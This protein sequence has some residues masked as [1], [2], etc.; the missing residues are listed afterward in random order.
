MQE[1]QVF[2]NPEIM[3][4]ETPA[5]KRLE[6]VIRGWVVLSALEK[7]YLKDLFHYNYISR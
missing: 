1:E 2:W 7:E 3:S 6:L 5:W 4:D